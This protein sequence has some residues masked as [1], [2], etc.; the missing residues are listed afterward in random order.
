MELWPLCTHSNDDGVESLFNRSKAYKASS[1]AVALGSGGCGRSCTRPRRK[2]ETL[3][4]IA[5]RKKDVDNGEQ[6][7]SEKYNSRRRGKD[8]VA[9]R[10]QAKY[11]RGGRIADSEEG[12]G[13]GKGCGGRAM[14]WVD[15]VWW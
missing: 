13:G 9:K 10:T 5:G 6:K 12:L 15:V 1:G 8:V 11:G 14:S 7:E 4:A 2:R 3:G